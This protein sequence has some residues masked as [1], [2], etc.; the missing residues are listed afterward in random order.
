MNMAKKSSN[1]SFDES[2]QILL[3]HITNSITRST[4]NTAAQAHT[5]TVRRLFSLYAAISATISAAIPE[6]IPADVAVRIAGNVIA[7]RHAYGT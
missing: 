2:L 4:I 6:T 3:S 5:A 1:S 7:A